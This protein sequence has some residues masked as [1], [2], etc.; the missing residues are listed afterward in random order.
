MMEI[1][2]LIQGRTQGIYK[3]SGAGQAGVGTAP[4]ATGR[5][6]IMDGAAL[7]QVWLLDTVEPGEEAATGD[8][9]NGRREIAGKLLNVGNCIVSPGRSPN[10][11]PELFVRNSTI[12]SS[13][14]V[15]MSCAHKQSDTALLAHQRGLQ[16][17]D[18][19]VA[20]THAT[21]QWPKVA[22]TMDCVIA[23]FFRVTMWLPNVPRRN[24]CVFLSASSFSR[25][26]ED[27]QN[28][29][30]IRASI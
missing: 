28:R 18:D 25:S 17:L 23:Q 2:L 22:R 27:A 26:Q 9:P 5:S 14:D 12:R 15:A 3:L 8:W 19:W 20:K 21:F 13:N 7:D 1:R 10:F 24:S 11:S 16:P 4:P 30:S 29:M 6:T